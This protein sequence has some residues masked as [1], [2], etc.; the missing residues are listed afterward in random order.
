MSNE[1]PNNVPALRQQLAAIPFSRETGIQLRDI[2]N[3]CALAELLVKAGFAP[4][5]ASVEYATVAILDG[6]MLGLNPMQAIQGIAVVNG[7]PCLYGDAFAAVVKS[8]PVFG[9]EKIE[10]IGS[11]DE[12]GIRVTVWR[13]GGEETPTVE[14]F[15][16]ADAKRAGLWGKQG[17][18]TQYPRQMLKHRALGF[19]YR[20][21][22]PDVLK[23]IRMAEE[24]RDVIDV[25]PI[26]GGQVAPLDRADPIAPK[27]KSKLRAALA[28]PAEKPAAV[29]LPKAEPKEVAP[30]PGATIEPVEAEATPE[31]VNP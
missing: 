29:D 22:F 19:A 18:W 31:P 7:R 15:T 3:A 6:A 27:Q 16:V 2:G 13:K 30:V 21:A 4:K 9:G 25:T 12:A 17:P 23:G 8:S 1:N 5:G 26:A 20:Q 28:L 11:G 24:E 10:T 14:Q